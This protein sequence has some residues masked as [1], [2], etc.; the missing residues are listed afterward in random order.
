MG[1]RGLKLPPG[2]EK[3]NRWPPHT[4]EGTGRENVAMHR[5]EYL[6]RR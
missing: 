4:M 6:G 2:P 3:R 1:G 5:R